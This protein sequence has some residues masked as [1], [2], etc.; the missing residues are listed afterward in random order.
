[1]EGGGRLEL[2]EHDGRRYLVQDGIETA[3]PRT[4]HVERELARIACAPFRPARQPRVW[5]LGLGLGELLDATCEALPQRRARFTVVEPVAALPGWLREQAPDSALADDERVEV[6]SDPGPAALRAR[7][8]GLHAI[9]LHP[10]TPPEAAPGSPWFEDR[11]WLEA[12]REALQSG[13]L[14]AIGS[15][16]KLGGLERRLAGAGFET[17]RHLVESNPRARRPRRHTILL[18]RR[19]REST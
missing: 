13:G 15:S 12:A 14:L 17:A 7:A 10:H 4:R 2:Q 1:L 19:Q 8:G 9:Q 11:G 3:G 5:I 16:T 18:A 6:V